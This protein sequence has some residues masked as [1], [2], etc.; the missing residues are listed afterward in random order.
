MARLDQDGATFDAEWLVCAQVRTA[1]PKSLWIATM[2]VFKN[3]IYNKY[4]FTPKMSVWVEVR[5]WCP[6]DQGCICGANI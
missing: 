1:Q 5:A 6:T 4:F 2:L 3:A